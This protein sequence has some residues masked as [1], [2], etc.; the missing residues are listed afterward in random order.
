MVDSI[1]PA[2]TPE[3]ERSVEQARRSG[4]LAGTAGSIRAVG[5][6]T[7][8]PRREARLRSVALRSRMTSAPASAPSCGC[9]TL[10][11]RHSPTRDRSAGYRTV[12]EAMGDVRLRETI[13]ALMMEDVLPT[14]KPL[15]DLDLRA[16]V[17]AILADPEPEHASFSRANRDGW[18]AEAAIR[19]LGNREGCARGRACDRSSAVCRWPHGCASCVALRSATRR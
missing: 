8:L 5:A 2:T 15:A 16:Y 13:E 10:P 9:S 17:R 6:R 12:G 4:L 14:L 18:L 1:T 3:L 19:I 7:R 11:T